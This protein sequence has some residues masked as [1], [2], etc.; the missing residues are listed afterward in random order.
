M[1]CAPP[2]RPRAQVFEQVDEAL[3]E[4][5]S[6]LIFEGPEERLRLTEN[7]Q[8][9]LMATSLAALRALEARSGRPARGAVRLRRR[10]FARRVLGARRRAAA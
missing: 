7:A 3:G 6:R 2:S 9:A 4:A 8:P 5:L 1:R 10:P